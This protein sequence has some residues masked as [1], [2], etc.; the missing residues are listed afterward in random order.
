MKGEAS[1]EKEL[2]FECN[3]MGWDYI[4]IPDT[5]MINAANRTYNR[6]QKRPF[7][8]IISAP[9][10]LLAVECKFNYGKLKEHQFETGRQIEDKNGMFVVLRK[11]DRTPQDLRYIAETSDGVRFITKF[12]C[13]ELLYSLADHFNLIVR[14]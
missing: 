14:K 13:K 4:K 1:F 5:K 2:Q 6:E 11:I 10:G 8:A 9:G 3:V 12:T 7:D